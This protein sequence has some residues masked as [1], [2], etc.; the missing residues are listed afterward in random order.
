MNKYI[1]RCCL[2]G[3]LAVLGSTVRYRNRNV[4]PLCI[5]IGSNFCKYFPDKNKENGI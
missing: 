5:K 3:E 1:H 4:H 2:C